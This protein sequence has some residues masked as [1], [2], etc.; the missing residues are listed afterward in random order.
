[1]LKVQSLQRDVIAAE[2]YQGPQGS[3]L[4]VGLVLYFDVNCFFCISLELFNGII[5][6]GEQIKSILP[7]YVLSKEQEQRSL[8]ES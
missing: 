5:H 1:M 8:P 7:L 6:S 4:K 3:D 2:T